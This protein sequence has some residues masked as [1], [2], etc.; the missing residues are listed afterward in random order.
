M[1]VDLIIVV[2]PAAFGPVIMIFLFMTTS[3]LIG[4]SYGG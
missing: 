2:L 4:V 3:F 1:S